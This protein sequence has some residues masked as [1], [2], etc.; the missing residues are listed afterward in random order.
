MSEFVW[1]EIHGFLSP[2]EYQRF[3]EYI[4]SQV[5]TGQAVEVP[6]NP[7]YHKGEIYGGRW[8]QD[9]GS[10]EIW[11]LVAPDFPFRGLWER[12]TGAT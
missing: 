9:A 12:V 5:A 2:S 3:V 6:V 10:G 4:E 7:Q 11:R 8:F 1:E